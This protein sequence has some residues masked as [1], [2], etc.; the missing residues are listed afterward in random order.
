MAFQGMNVGRKRGLLLGA[1]LAVLA[2]LGAASNALADEEAF[3]AAASHPFLFPGLMAA[4]PL[5]F[6][7]AVQLAQNQTQSPAEG[8]NLAQAQIERGQT[9]RNR[10][11][12]DY[13]AQGVRV[14]SFR[15]LPQMIVAPLFDDNVFRTNTGEKEDVVTVLSPSVNLESDWGQHALNFSAGSDLGFY[16][17]NTHEDFKDYHFASDGRLD[18]TRDTRVSGLAGLY[19]LHQG[20]GDPDDPVGALEPTEFDRYVGQ[21]RGSHRMGRFTGILTGLFQRFDYQDV[22]RRAAGL[23]DINNDDRDRNRYEGSL[24]VNYEIVPDYSAFVRGGGNV[25]D[26]DD[27]VDDNGFNRDNHGYDVVAGAEI[28]FGGIVFG[29]FFAGYSWTNRDDPALSDF[30]GYNV[31]ADITWNVTRLTTITGTVERQISDTTLR[32]ASGSF[33]TTAGVVVD[34]ELL[35]NLIVSLNASGQQNDFEGIDRT[36]Y[37]FA[38]GLAVDYFINRY[39]FVGALYEHRERLSEGALQGTDFSVNIAGV[40]AGAQF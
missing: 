7:P 4:Q 13:D 15:L 18:V 12:P 30:S 27:G 5:R 39:F 11:R 26:Y 1:G 36:D 25:E 38:G 20:R 10:P 23:P 37:N 33:V 9:V 28:D 32:G 21:V 19:H 34:H 35:R 17:D 22:P 24:Q 14:G 6:E 16:V 2:G 40:R 8:T 29:N 3:D 31:G